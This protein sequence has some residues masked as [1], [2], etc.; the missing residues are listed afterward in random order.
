M[1]VRFVA[2]V[3]LGCMSSVSSVMYGSEIAAF[4]IFGCDAKGTQDGYARWNTGPIDACWDLFVYEGE[5]VQKG[6]QPKWL[7]DPQTH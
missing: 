5:R 3:M 7:N 6:E 4:T 1:N 2:M